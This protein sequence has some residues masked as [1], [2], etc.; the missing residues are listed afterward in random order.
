VSDEEKVLRVV[1][2]A[3]DG[4]RQ[5][6]RDWLR[7]E[8]SRE[9]RTII[10]AGLKTVEY[11]WPLGMPTVRKMEP[12]LWEVRSRLTKGVARVLFT[13]MGRQ[14]ILLHGFVKKSQ[15]TP[16]DDLDTARRR[17]MLLK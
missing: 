10:G 12:G 16:A 2:F 14:M 1:F 9:D 13:V 17:L 11:R 15:K 3:T 7:Q 6:V 8:L 4:G 5:P